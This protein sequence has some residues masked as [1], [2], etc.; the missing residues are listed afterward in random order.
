MRATIALAT[1]RHAARAGQFSRAEVLLAL[2]I[3]LVVAFAT[4]RPALLDH[5]QWP[6]GPWSYAWARIFMAS[7]VAAASGLVFLVLRRGLGSGT[8]LG[9]PDTQY[10]VAG[11]ALLGVFAAL[12]HF[13]PLL[14]PRE[15][16]RKP[17]A[18]TRTAGALAAFAWGGAVVL[19]AYIAGLHGR[20]YQYPGEKLPWVPAI[21]L[22]LVTGWRLGWHYADPFTSEMR[23][24]TGPWRCA[25][26]T[27]SRLW[28]RFILAPA[29]R[30]TTFRR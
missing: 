2:L 20:V 16:G 27:V 4:A 15:S 19:T 22:L 7:L 3:G 17:E 8:Q 29:R 25:W 9:T 1:V 11:G 30:L 5:D 12:V 6:Y 23:H 28:S 24:S 21:A 26:R 13:E 14:R 10:V 18:L